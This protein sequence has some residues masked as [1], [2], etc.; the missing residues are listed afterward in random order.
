MSSHS[1]NFRLRHCAL[2]L[3]A[4]FSRGEQM[5]VHYFDQLG[6]NFV[7]F[8]LDY[9]E[10]PPTADSEHEIPDVFVGLALA[11]NL[12]FFDLSTNVL[13]SGL[14]GRAGAK[15]WTEKILLLL[16]RE[17]DPCDI[18]GR[19]N[20]EAAAAGGFGSG[21]YDVGASVGV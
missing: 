11:Y 18:L 4:I 5:P 14:A 17:E 2:L 7:S 1:L 8:L 21:H 16:N 13:V 15:A 9:I 19:M 6:S 10:A 3:T 12:Q 20:P